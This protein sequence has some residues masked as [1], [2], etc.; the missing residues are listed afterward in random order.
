MTLTWKQLLIGVGLVIGLFA[1]GAGTATLAHDCGGKYEV[2]VKHTGEIACDLSEL[3]V[4]CVCECDSDVTFTGPPVVPVAPNEPCEEFEI[5]PAYSLSLG[6]G[7]NLA[8]AQF[9]YSL[10]P[11]WAV[12]G[13]AL[14]TRV[15]S[16]KY[17]WNDY[18]YTNSVPSS[19]DWR[20]YVGV[21]W[22]K[23]KATKA[24]P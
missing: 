24:G 14:Y 9:D 1:S 19:D 18:S 11:R 5:V 8:L 10:T 2:D 17:D 15:S 23:Y 20:A 4:T 13:G 16:V 7:E 12:F 22:T 21:K 3:E 6:G